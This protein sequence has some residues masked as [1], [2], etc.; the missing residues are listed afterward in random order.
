[1][2]IIFNIRYVK[3]N[4]HNQVEHKF[5]FDLNYLLNNI[6]SLNKHFVWRRCT[7]VEDYICISQD[8]ISY[9]GA[10]QCTW[11]LIVSIMYLLKATKAL[12]SEIVILQ[13]LYTLTTQQTNNISEKTINYIINTI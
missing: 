3:I 1:M 13:I 4:N 9:F 7:K 8:T 12:Y 10:N 11:Y 5:L 6:I 2:F